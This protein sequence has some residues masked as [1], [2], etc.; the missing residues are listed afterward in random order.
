MGLVKIMTLTRRQA[1]RKGKQIEGALVQYLEAKG[2]ECARADLSRFP[3]VIYW[4][5]HD[6]FFAECK[7]ASSSKSLSAAKYSF[8]V[9]LQER[10]FFPDECPV[11]LWA[12]F[13]PE[14]TWLVFESI[15][16]E[17]VAKGER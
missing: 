5:H 15:D 3:D 10:A 7:Y 9:A 14:E 13:Q 1:A 12:W 4:D 17:L 6:V 11:E 8:K 16:G 2:Y